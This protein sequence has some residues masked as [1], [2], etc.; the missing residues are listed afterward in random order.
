MATTTMTKPRTSGTKTASRSQNSSNNGNSTGNTTSTS[1]RSRSTGTTTTTRSK[2]QSNGNGTTTTSTIQK[3]TSRRSSTASTTMSRSAMKAQ[4]GMEFKKFFVDELK[5]IYW[6]EKQL[7]KALL[8]MKRAA[9]SQE[10]QSA[11]EKHA[12]ETNGHITVVEKVFAALGEKPKTKKCEAMAGIIEEAQS[13]IKDTDRATFIRDAG[14]ILG[15]QK[16]EHYE[17]ATYGTLR[18]FSQYLKNKRVTTMLEGILNNEK[19]TDVSLTKLAEGF[20]NDRAAQE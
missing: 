10:L 3:P 4:S 2:N 13:I 1:S 11:F 18:I 15:A 16:A 19:Y 7:S 5:D 6:A 14:L 17:I 8:K 20:I 12:N 9:T